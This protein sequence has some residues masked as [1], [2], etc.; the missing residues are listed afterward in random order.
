MLKASAGCSLRKWKS[1]MVA[2]S[3]GLHKIS[4]SVGMR[5][6]AI[7]SLKISRYSWRRWLNLKNRYKS[8]IYWLLITSG[9]KAYCLRLDD[10]LSSISSFKSCDVIW[11]SI[12][13]RCA[14]GICA[15]VKHNEYLSLLQKKPDCSISDRTAFSPVGFSPNSRMMLECCMSN[16]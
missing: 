7:S 4:F 13:L 5:C 9:R 15:M 11:L 6:R 3:S 14:C 2:N 12:I 1:A 10:L 8:W 16:G